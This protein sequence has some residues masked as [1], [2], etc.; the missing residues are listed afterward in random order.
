MA[1]LA[2]LKCSRTVEKC[3]QSHVW[4]IQLCILSRLYQWCNEASSSYCTMSTVASL[5]TGTEETSGQLPGCRPWGLETLRCVA[6]GSEQKS[7]AELADSW[8][9][10]PRIFLS[11]AVMSV[12]HLLSVQP[13]R[14][15]PQRVV[16]SPNGSQPYF[17]LHPQHY[18]VLLFFTR[19]WCFSLLP[20]HSQ[21]F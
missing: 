10:S 15:R 21:P 11:S 20:P 9:T 1:W 4:C 18:T 12:F 2:T 16:F 7:I 8:T 5:D 17:I 14:I 3:S 6:T 13:R 19:K